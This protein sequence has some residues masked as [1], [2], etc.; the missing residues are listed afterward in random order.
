MNREPISRY[1][2]IASVLFL[3]VGIFIF[4]VVQEYSGGIVMFILST[5]HIVLAIFAKKSEKQSNGGETNEGSSF[6]NNTNYAI[7]SFNN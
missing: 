4:F 7:P 6:G 5:M 1:F 3:I 2:E